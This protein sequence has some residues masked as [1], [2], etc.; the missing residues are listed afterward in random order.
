LTA[1]L[2]AVALLVSGAITLTPL[3]AAAPLPAG[4][5]VHDVQAIALLERPQ[6]GE[7]KT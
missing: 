2:T 1:Q 4:Q 7:E 6:V 5:S 3:A